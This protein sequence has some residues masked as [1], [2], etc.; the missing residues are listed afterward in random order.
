MG[1]TNTCSREDIEFN[2]DGETIRGW[3]FRPS[4][5]PDKAPLIVLGNGFAAVK[6]MGMA[7]YAERLT[8]DARWVTGQ[9]LRADGGI[10]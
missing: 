5:G 3:L 2:A 1:D 9:N 10:R 6:E 8:D 7:A 4:A